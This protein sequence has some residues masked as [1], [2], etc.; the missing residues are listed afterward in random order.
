MKE[1][2]TKITVETY[3]VLIISRHDS[4]S[5][6][7]CASCGKQVAIKTVND[8]CS[9]TAGEDWANSLDRDSWQVVTDLP[10][11]IDSNLKGDKP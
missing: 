3:E 9:P 7:W 11:P 5:R 10:Q 2:K 4:L 6:N 8:T 1:R